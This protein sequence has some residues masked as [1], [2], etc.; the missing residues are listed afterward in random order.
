VLADVATAN[1]DDKLRA[2][3]VFLGKVTRSTVTADDVRT[4]RAA[5]VS[6]AQIDDALAVCFVFNVIDRLADTFEFHVPEA[7]ALEVSAKHLLKRGY[8]M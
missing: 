6:R 7:A 5:G 3:L 4:L 2:T 8:K 1:I